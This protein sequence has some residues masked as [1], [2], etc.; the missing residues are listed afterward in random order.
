MTRLRNWSTSVG[1]HLDSAEWHDLQKEVNYEY[2]R[3]ECFP[4]KKLIFR[5]FRATPLNRVSVV[6]LGQDPYPTK[7]NAIGLSFAVAKGTKTPASL[8]NIMREMEE[9]TGSKKPLGLHHAKQGVLLLNAALTVKEGKPGSHAK[10][11]KPFT[12]AVIEVLQEVPVLVWMLWGNKAQEYEPFLQ[13]P[14]HQV[15]RAAHPSPLARGAFFGCRHFSKANKYL[16]S[17]G[18]HVIS[19]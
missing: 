7:G 9:D 17:Q 8:K 1:E 15:L 16:K 14:H 19:W 13:N 10:L 3:Y 11:W 2:S 18:N 6:I 5:A 12:H 4:P